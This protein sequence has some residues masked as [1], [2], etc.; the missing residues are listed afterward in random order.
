[1]VYS[2]ALWHR[3]C[4][5]LTGQYLEV[6]AVSLIGPAMLNLT[7]Y[8]FHFECPIQFKIG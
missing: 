2:L 6:H 1:M 5:W 3:F 4:C 8:R 7:D